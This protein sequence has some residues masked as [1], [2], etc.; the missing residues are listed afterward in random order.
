MRVPR[1]Y[2][3]QPIS[4]GELSLDERAA[5]YVGQVLRCALGGS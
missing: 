5:H 3:D 1:V 2:I 4:R